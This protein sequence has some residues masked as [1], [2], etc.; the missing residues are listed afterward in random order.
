MEIEE[1]SA[2]R[3]ARLEGVT[4][5]LMEEYHR[6]FESREGLAICEAEAQ[7]CQ[8]CYTQFTVNDQARL[9]GGKILVR[10]SSCQRILYLA[11]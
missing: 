2:G 8:G 11:E 7:Y 10:C 4:P 3:E 5:E 1:V 6:L 9:Q